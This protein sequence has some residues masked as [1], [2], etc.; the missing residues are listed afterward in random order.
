[1][2]QVVIRPM[3][4]YARFA[5]HLQGGEPICNSGGLYASRGAR[6]HGGV[7][8]CSKE[9]MYRVSPFIA[10]DSAPFPAR[11]PNAAGRFADAHM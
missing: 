2:A 4:R 9:P 7:P 1:M 8:I 10:T 3:Y 6:V 5:N 11:L